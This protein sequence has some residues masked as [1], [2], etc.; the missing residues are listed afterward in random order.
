[1]SAFNLDKYLARIG[2]SGALAATL[3]TLHAVT[4]AH[5]HS[6]P[7]ENLDVLLGRPIAL[8]PGAVFDKLVTQERGGYC[9]EQN[10][11][12]LSALLAMG[13]EVTPISAR[14]RIDRPRTMVPPRTHMF[15]RVR[16]ANTDYF[17]D[18]GVGALSLTSALQFDVGAE[19]TTPHET[20]RI[21]H[22]SGSYFHQA[23]LGDIWSDV[24]EFSG[25]EMF[26]IDREV[27]NWFTSAHPLSHFRNRLIVSRAAANGSRITLLN[28]ELKRRDRNGHAVVTAIESADALLQT[29]QAEFGL[30]FA[31]GTRFVGGETVPPVWPV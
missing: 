20:R 25:E 13:Y 24:C 18:C 22:E 3:N 23:L 30:N 12:L 10:R 17:T 19:Q 8:E 6:I 1:M 2:L 7:F 29:L 26:E 5:T 4:S 28:G 21:V 27:A 9:F 14:V 11:L 31:A 16:I 15:L